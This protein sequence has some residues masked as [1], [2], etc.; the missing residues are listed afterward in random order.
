MKSR[1]QNYKYAESG[2]TNVTLTGVE[3]R[4]C[5]QC[6]YDE[7]VI[8]RMAQL[9]RILAEAVARK[10]GRLIPEEVRF[11]RQFLGWSGVEFARAFGV[12]PETVS[13]WEHGAGTPSTAA[14]KLLRLLALIS[15]GNAAPDIPDTSEQ[16]QHARYEASLGS[17]WK[18][19]A[20]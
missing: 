1:R 18:V 15:Q 10:P 8:P 11:L 9:H 3:V 2:L 16:P 17:R 4:H 5:P 6:G 19:E 7:V 13:R 12:A 14:E 20:A